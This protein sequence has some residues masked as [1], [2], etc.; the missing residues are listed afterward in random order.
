MLLDG[1]LPESTA[2]IVAGI[3]A[4]GFRIDDVKV[5]A[6]SH[7]HFD[8]AGGIAEL[9]RLSGARVVASQASAPILKHGGVGRD[10][11]QFGS[12]APIRAVKRVRAVK[13]GETLHVGPIA[14]TA[15]LTPGHTPGGTSWTWISCE[16]GRCLNIVYADSLTAVSAD[17]YLFTKHSHA[18]K[19]FERSFATLAALPCDILVSTHPEVSGLWDRLAK[20][21]QGDANA[22]VDATACRR[23]VDGARDRLAKRV[24]EETAG[25]ASKF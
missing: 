18:L 17:G 9:Q 25:R 12:L 4:L 6:S 16:N 15:H 11:P 8:H 1:D 20:R 14:L 13:D 21:E 22:L 5:I 3:R 23:Y 10:D 7:V 2:N 24:A 19:D